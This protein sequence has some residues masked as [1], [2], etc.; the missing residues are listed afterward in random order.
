MV[1]FSEIWLEGWEKKT[2][3]LSNKILKIMGDYGKSPSKIGG[4][5]E[6]S[7]VSILLEL[8]SQRK[9]LD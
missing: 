6:F 7:A 3:N 1:K 5:S 8:E 9:H 4:G 2:K